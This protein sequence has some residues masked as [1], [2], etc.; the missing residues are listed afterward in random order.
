VVLVFVAI[1]RK[2]FFELFSKYTHTSPY[3]IVYD[4]EMELMIRFRNI[5]PKARHTYLFFSD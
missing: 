1:G 5:L 2:C 4:C 3:P